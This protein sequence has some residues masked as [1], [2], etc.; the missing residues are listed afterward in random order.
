MASVHPNQ[1]SRCLHVGFDHAFF[2]G[3]VSHF[4][5]CLHVFRIGLNG[6]FVA[7]KRLLR[8]V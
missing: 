3:E 6:S 4:F 2:L 5:G 8:Q 7:R 1:E